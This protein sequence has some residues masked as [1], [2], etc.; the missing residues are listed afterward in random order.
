MNRQSLSHLDKDT[1]LPLY[2]QIKNDIRDKI[3]HQDW[4]AGKRV[5]SEN[6]LVENLGVSRMTVHRALRELTHEGLLERVHGL[7]T[8][9]AEPARHASLIRLQDIA[10]EVRNRGLRHRCKVLGLRSIKATASMAE[11]MEVKPSTYLFHLRAVHFQED[12]PIQFEDRV[13]NPAMAPEFPN[14]DFTEHTATEYLVGQ[15]KPDEMEHIVQ[16]V[17]PDKRVSAAL[18][19]EP[20]EPCL[21]LLRRTWKDQTVVTRV[22]LIYPGSRY[23]LV[24]RYQTNQYPVILT[25]N[26]HGQNQ[27][28]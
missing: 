15:I 12:L 9:V 18:M 10:E 13:V 25:E 22:A 2:Q 11:L 5:P 27:N 1:A 8:F 20:D 19:I 17:S 23:D 4:L 16:A 24:E 14:Q 7:G 6:E 26:Q 28:R 21:R 3:Q